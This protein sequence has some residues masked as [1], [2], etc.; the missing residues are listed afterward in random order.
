MRHEYIIEGLEKIISLF[1][2]DNDKHITKKVH[3]QITFR[4]EVGSVTSL[5]AWEISRTLQ[6]IL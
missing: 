4:V 3:R 5:N 2:F 6:G 1:V